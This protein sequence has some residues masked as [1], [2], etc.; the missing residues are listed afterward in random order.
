VRKASNNTRAND[1]LALKESSNLDPKALAQKYIHPNRSKNS[2]RREEIT[3]FILLSPQHKSRLF[4]TH[5]FKVFAPL[6]RIS[7]VG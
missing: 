5:K 7:L 6:T 2:R 4:M 1:P 3:I